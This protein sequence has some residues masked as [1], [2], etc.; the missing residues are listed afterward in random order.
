MDAIRSSCLSP[1]S[2]A[3]LR[4]FDAAARLRS[5][6]R[7]AQELHVSQG[8]VS[9]Q[10][11][12]LEEWLGHTLLLRTPSGLRLTPRGEELFAVTCATFRDLDTTVRGLHTAGRRG[13]VNVSSPPSFAMLW[14]TL[15]LGDFYRTHPH[16]TLRIVG[17]FVRVDR[18][19]M[20]SEGIAAA[21]RFDTCEA[22]AP[23]AVELF[24]EWLVPVA[25]PA[26]MQAHP[27]LRN[28]R[29]LEGKNL[30]HA[31]DPSEMSA[32]TEEWAQWLAEAGVP[33]RDSALSEGA[34]FN[35]SQLAVQ[36]ALGGQGIAMARVA[37]VQGYLLQGRLLVPFRRRIRARGS[38]RIIGSPSHP[39]TRTILDWLVDQAHGFEHQRDA[40]F[41][42]AGIVPA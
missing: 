4:C 17:E 7:A 16:L 23:E 6:T 40:L 41:D 9:Q 28:A 13:P 35:L 27:N 15:R 32:P 14:L 2:L 8:A 25:A 26:F 33:F 11:K 30:L 42:S 19:L 3:W 10:V 22:A 12:K 29:D 20:A 21:V 37:L 31:A 1:S 36:A 39:Q 38:Y 34:Q 24:D 5:F 18:E